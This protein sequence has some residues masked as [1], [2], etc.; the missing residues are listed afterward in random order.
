MIT[1][2]FY[3][4]IWG[5]LCAVVIIPFWLKRYRQ[6]ERLKYETR[7]STEFKEFMML[8]SSSLQAGYSVERAFKSSENEM[9]N[10]Y[11]EESILLPYI[12]KLNN[13]VSMNIPLEKAFL[14]MASSIDL[15]DALSLADI[16][17]FA[18]RSGGDYGKNIRNT[19]IKIEEKLNVQQEIDTLT[20]EK[21]LEMKVMSCMPMGIL[22]YISLTSGEFIEPLYTTTVGFII[23][24]ICLVL[25]GGLIVLGEKMIAI[26]V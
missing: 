20:A 21:Q 3:R 15:E 13:A 26:D 9:K 7:L 14:E 10:L 18:K 1:I 16:L 11:T 6:S 5:L 22:A 12:H 17:S 25:Y 19:A 4:S 23:M 2:L 8:I 24:T